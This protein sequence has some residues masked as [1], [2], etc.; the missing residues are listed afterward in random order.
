MS[1]HAYGFLRNEADNTIYRNAVKVALQDLANTGKIPASATEE[2]SNI[3][4]RME[5]VEEKKTTDNKYGGIS[6]ADAMM[7]FWQTY[8]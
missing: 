8:Q 1:F 5:K 4:R 7:K 2:F 6:P 3:C